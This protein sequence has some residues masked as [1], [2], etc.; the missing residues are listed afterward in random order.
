MLA[1][2]IIRAESCIIST[3]FFSNTAVKLNFLCFLSLT[4]LSIKIMTLLKNSPK[5]GPKFWALIFVEND[6]AKALNFSQNR[7]GSL[8]VGPAILEIRARIGAVG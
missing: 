1:L 7:V 2:K 3:E 8:I 6:E 5:V 4:K